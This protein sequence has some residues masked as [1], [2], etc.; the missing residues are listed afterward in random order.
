MVSNFVV[1]AL[2]GDDITLYGDGQQ[3]RSF[4]Y[5][6]DLVEDAA[7]RD[8]EGRGRSQHRKSGWDGKMAR[9]VEY[10]CGAQGVF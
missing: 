8:M 5:V 7:N 6:S 9:R 10:P 1:Q 3:T 4:C 2:R